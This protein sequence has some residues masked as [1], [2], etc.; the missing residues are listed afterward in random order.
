[1][2]EKS[3]EFR[4]ARDVIYDIIKNKHKDYA[5]MKYNNYL[6]YLQKNG[7]DFN[8]KLFNADLSAEL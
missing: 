7:L 6:N 5:R 8:T 2:S 1:M 3:L 4:L